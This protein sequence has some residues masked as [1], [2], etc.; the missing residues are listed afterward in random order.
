[1]YKIS[2]GVSIASGI[3][4]ST[5]WELVAISIVD[6]GGMG[7]SQLLTLS[8]SDRK[9]VI[10]EVYMFCSIWCSRIYDRYIGKL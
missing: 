7:V 3:W 9:M 6:A 1:M 10:A 5:S 2:W 4:S 8:S